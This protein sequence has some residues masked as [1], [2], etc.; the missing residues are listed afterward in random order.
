MPAP[1][2][3]PTPTAAPAAGA[4]QSF[5]FGRAVHAIAYSGS[6]KTLAVG[7]EG[8][9]ISFWEPASNAQQ[10][11]TE[12]FSACTSLAYSN[13]G[14]SLAIGTA[15]GEV[16]IWNVTTSKPER[17]LKHA[18]LSDVRSV[19]W[20]GGAGEPLVIVGDGGGAVRMFSATSG[21]Q[22]SVLDLAVDAGPIQ[23]L[24]RGSKSPP[25]IFTGHLDGTVAVWNL[26][27]RSIQ[28][29]LC[30]SGASVLEA[31]AKPNASSSK[32]A[33]VTAW[34]HEMCYALAVSPDEK[35]LAVAARDLE[36]WELDSPRYAVRR[37]QLPGADGDKAYR[38]VAISAD[39]AIVAAGSAAGICT[40]VETQS[41]TVLAQETMPAAVTA[42]A[43]N[44]SDRTRLAVA[45]Q[46]GQVTVIPLTG[47]AQKRAA[48]DFDV[49][50]LIETAKTLV[51]DEEWYDAARLLNAAAAFQLSVADKREFDNIRFKAK[52]AV[53]GLVDAVNPKSIPADEIEDA[54]GNLQ[55]AIDI[56]PAGPLG[57]EARDKLKQLPA[58]TPESL[59]KQAEAADKA[60]ATTK[61]P[62]GRSKV[63][64]RP[65]S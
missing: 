11:V 61:M 52:K 63:R 55:L 26:G 31:L 43:F 10:R 41:W 22:Q 27:G 50:K 23:A 47:M 56:D 38:Y 57:K 40:L 3:T 28:K 35:L 21:N 54:A 2:P 24:V 15:D 32:E 51:T 30:G 53:Q 59:A 45:T 20:S 34:G 14:R 9:E 29:L 17:T 33:D 44:P 58:T 12:A 49:A 5:N 48:P 25:L 42:L 62:P 18:D 1:A 46:D 39:G 36:L 19:A 37:R 6:G 65:K 64:K 8:G 60:A 16:L 13:S 7:G 4:R